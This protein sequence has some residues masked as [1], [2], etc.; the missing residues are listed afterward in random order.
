M[1]QP[2]WIV[3]FVNG[4]GCFSVGLFNRKEITI[5]CKVESDFIVVQHERNLQ[6]F[7]A[8]KDYFGCGFAKQS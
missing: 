7:Y 4:E 3:G 2:Q 8:L 5:G 1:V 6:V